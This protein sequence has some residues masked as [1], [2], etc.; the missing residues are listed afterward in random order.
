[1]VIQLSPH[2]EQTHLPAGVGGAE[3]PEKPAEKTE[4]GVFARI[5]SGLLR[6]TEAAEH[7]E[8]TEIPGDIPTAETAESG[9]I[10]LPLKGKSI[11]GGKAA[12]AVTEK[13]GTEKNRKTVESEPELTEQEHTILF[14]IDRLFGQ[15]GEQNTLGEE[16]E[17]AVFETVFEAPTEDSPPGSLKAVEAVFTEMAQPQAIAAE[18]KHP[19]P[20]KD[21]VPVVHS[22]AELDKNPKNNGEKVKIRQNTAE[23]PSGSGFITPEKAGEGLFRQIETKNINPGEKEGRNRLEETRAKDRRRGVTFEVR[24]FRSSGEQTGAVKEN[25]V[26]MRAETRPGAEAARE[27]TLEL[28][29]PGQGREAPS[30][31]TSWE[32]RAGEA[33]ENL[34]ARELHQNFNND[35]VRHASVMLRDGNEGTIRLALKPENLGSVKIHLK[36]AENKITG[37]IVVESAEALR[38]FERELDSLEQ[39]F[40]NSGFDGANLEMSLATDGRGADRQWQEM[41][42]SQF[43]PGQYAAS[44][45]DAAVERMEM[46]LTLDVYH[47]GAMAINVLA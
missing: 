8:H 18:G 11:R 24:D 14:T 6:K 34:L 30:A 3:P 40:R 37:R 5:L 22:T 46:P 12:E 35:I 33:F 25:V 45:Y 16:K 28:H 4:A 36:M 21:A 29:L 13:T 2:T 38:A 10:N 1:M 32:A 41:E 7:A 20:E 17:V 31:V 19:L 23:T 43:L 9:E 44:H 42:A 26:Q 27:I 39:A 47:H 15:S